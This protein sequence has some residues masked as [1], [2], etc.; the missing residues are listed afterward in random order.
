MAMR[1][2]DGLPEEIGYEI[3]EVF[4]GKALDENQF[5]ISYE[6][7][8][9]DVTVLAGRTSFAIP[10][11]CRLKEALFQVKS[12]VEAN[13]EFYERR[14]PEL[15]TIADQYPRY[16]FFPVDKRIDDS[17]YS[18]TQMGKEIIGRNGQ[19]AVQVN[20]PEPEGRCECVI[21]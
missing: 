8:T 7:N 17:S 1:I 14:V 20:L 15:A 10:E 9:F 2:G 21:L 19:R 18:I 3:G 16:A 11:G 12:M 5:P 4:D 6:T 13:R